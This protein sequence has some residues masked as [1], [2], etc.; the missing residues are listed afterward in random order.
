MAE[1]PNDLDALEVNALLDRMYHAMIAGNVWTAR[2][3]GRLYRVTVT[4]ELLGAQ[5]CGCDPKAHWTCE[6]HRDAA[7]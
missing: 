1:Q 3:E 5:A 4:R 7:P 6:Q 2:T